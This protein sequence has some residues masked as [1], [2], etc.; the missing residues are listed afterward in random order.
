M[1]RR[2]YC[3]T[4]CAFQAIHGVLM[5]F[6]SKFGIWDVAV[7]RLMNDI[8]IDNP[9][10]SKIRLTKWI[11]N[12]GMVLFIEA[13]QASF[14]KFIKEYEEKNGTKPVISADY[15]AS[16]KRDGFNALRTVIIEEL[17][18]SE[19]KFQLF[20]DHA[21]EEHGAF[22]VIQA[23]IT[24]LILERPMPPDI[25]FQFVIDQFLDYKDKQPALGQEIDDHILLM[26]EYAAF[27]RMPTKESSSSSVIS[28]G[29]FK[30]KKEKIEELDASSLT[31]SSSQ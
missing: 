9:E 6:F 12:K 14:K 15:M 27:K 19:E 4:I 7:Q 8:C 2:F 5:N 25:G 10:V 23:A 22:Y 16:Q 20:L 18:Y 28:A 30:E 24:N 21:V 17:G 11:Y 26:R 31:L 13:Q 1:Y 29:F 3:S